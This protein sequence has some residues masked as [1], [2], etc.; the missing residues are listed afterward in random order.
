MDATTRPTWRLAFALTYRLLWREVLRFLRQRGRVLGAIGTPLL[1]WFVLGSGFGRSLSASSNEG[2]YFAYF[3]PGAAL[4]VVLFTAIFAAISVIE[5]R[6]SGF[7]QG[8]LI[9][10][11]PAWSLVLGKTLGGALLGG[12]QGWLLLW[13]APLI[14]LPIAGW[15]LLAAAPV[16]LLIGLSMSTLGFVSAWRTSSVQGFHAVMNLLLMP[17]WLLSGALFPIEGAATWMQYLM[18]INPLHYGLRALQGTL[19]PSET[20]AAALGGQLVLLAAFCLALTLIAC[21]QIRHRRPG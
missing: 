13:L 9:A 6:D 10:P 2:G 3:L 18:R 8:A 17:M 20:S 1:F 19:H 15:N 21:W 12:L 11:V 7:L 5:D 16:L 14:G 4:L